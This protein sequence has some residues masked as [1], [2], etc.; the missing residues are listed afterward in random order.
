M[1]DVMSR[2]KTLHRPRLLVRT[3]RI[4]AAAYSRQ[5]D[6][7]RILGFGADRKPTATI[8]RLLELEQEVNL[9]RLTGDAG[10]ILT[11][12][13]EILIALMGEAN[14]LAASLKTQFSGASNLNA[15]LQ[16]DVINGAA[17]KSAA[18]RPLSP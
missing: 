11:R 15:A 13:I 5:R 16:G 12:H 9:Q 18:A 2:L 1:Q 7:R 6:L 8:L 3:A 4:G 10:Y 14:I 17:T